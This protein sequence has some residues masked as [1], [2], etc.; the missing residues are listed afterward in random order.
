MRSNKFD[1]FI[2]A[3][4]MKPECSLVNSL[5]DTGFNPIVIGD[6]KEVSQ[7]SEALLGGVEAAIGIYFCK[8]YNVIE[9]L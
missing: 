4:G 7:I 5:K 8:D 9:L 1:F 3:V 2:S 6:A